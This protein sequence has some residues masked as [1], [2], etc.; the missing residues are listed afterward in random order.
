MNRECGIRLH[1]LKEELSLNLW[2]ISRPL[3][4]A[5]CGEVEKQPGV[6]FQSPKI[7]RKSS[8]W[9]RQTA[10]GSGSQLYLMRTSKL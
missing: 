5:S 7:M 10:M 9:D 4:S 2:A 1:P 3:Q 8:T 6:G